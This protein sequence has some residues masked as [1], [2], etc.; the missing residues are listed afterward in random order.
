M[1]LERAGDQLREPPFRRQRPNRID[2]G[3]R[4]C[5]P[6]YVEERARRKIPRAV[7]VRVR[8]SQHLDERQHA[9]F[10]EQSDQER[11]FPAVLQ[12]RPSHCLGEAGAHQGELPEHLHVER[13]VS[14][15]IEVFDQL[16]SECRGL[17]A[18]QAQHRDGPLNRGNLRA[19]GEIR[20]VRHRQ[21]TRR[22]RRI[23]LDHVR[24]VNRSGPGVIDQVEDT[25]RARRVGRQFRLREQ[26][27][28]FVAQRFPL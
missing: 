15:P 25:G 6:L 14:K 20:R 23:R 16:E 2:M 13:D 24:K 10:L 27:S 18:S 4:E 17:D 1:P 11:L 28:Q 21:Q 12:E 26:V 3:I 19:L 7:F 5:L 8:V 22:E 9:A